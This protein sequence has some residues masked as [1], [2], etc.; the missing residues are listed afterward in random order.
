MIRTKINVEWNKQKRL[1]GVVYMDVTK[2]TEPINNDRVVFEITYYVLDT[3]IERITVEE[4]AW[5]KDS[6]GAFVL[7]NSGNKIPVLD[8]V[9]NQLRILV[10]KNTVTT[11]P[12]EINKEYPNYKISTFYTLFPALQPSQHDDVMISQIDY[13]NSLPD[14]N[15]NYY[16]EL[17][18]ND[19][20]IVTPAMKADIF[21]TVITDI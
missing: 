17:T 14:N 21:K 3:I 10:F 6:N 9:G 15:M 18:A 12:R 19:M 5:Q 1:S 13:N 7:D 11:Y 4:L 2:R 8:S 20:E 16:W